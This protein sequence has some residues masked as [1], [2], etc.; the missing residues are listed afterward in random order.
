MP[1]YLNHGGYM[2]MNKLSARAPLRD[3]D[4]MKLPARAPLRDMDHGYMQM[5]TLPSRMYHD[6]TEQNCRQILSHVQNC[7]IC[8]H[9]YSPHKD[10]I[11]NSRASG[12]GSDVLKFEMSHAA[13]FTIVALIIVLI[14][15]IIVRR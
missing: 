12:G 5:N 3:M 14:L 8:R 10:V 15:L 2:Q 1:T 13:M 11:M 9:V 6:E 7:P 4:Q